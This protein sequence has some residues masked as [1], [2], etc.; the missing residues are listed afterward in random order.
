[1]SPGDN[2]VLTIEV[3]PEYLRSLNEWLNSE[4]DLRGQVRAGRAAPEPGKMGGTVELLTVALGSG[5]AVA[6]LLRSI[7]TWLARRGHDVTV[8][9][10]DADG[11]E[12]QFSSKS[13]NL[14]PE[15]VFRE[16]SGLFTGL[17]GDDSAGK[18][19]SA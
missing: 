1:M 17:R 3:A 9:L 11:R 10:K 18:G 5:G 4:A 12:F 6:V 15:K 16:A 7:T 2:N 8:S 13:K 14:D 19:H